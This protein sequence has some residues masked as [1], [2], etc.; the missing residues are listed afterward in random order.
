MSRRF[1]VLVNPAAAGGRALKR[2]PAGHRPSSTGLGRTTGWCTPAT[3]DT[4]AT[5]PRARRSAG[6]TVAAMGGDGL[7]RPLARRLRDTD[8]A[9][10]IIPG[11]RGNDY[12]RVLGIPTEPTAGGPAGRGGR[13]QR[14]IDV[15][16]VDGAPYLGHRQLRLRLRRQPDRQ[17][18]QG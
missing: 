7:L 10:A 13:G 4:P 14:M 1:L 3:S 16:E 17:R 18:G 12:A 15:A 6:E 9:L 5:R 8:A 2:L 11:G